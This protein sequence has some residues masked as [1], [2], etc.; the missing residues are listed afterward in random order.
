MSWYNIFKQSIC[1][2]ELS[3]IEDF[4]YQIEL[5]TKINQDMSSQ[6]EATKKQLN[7][8]N[9]NN[10]ILLN[11]INGYEKQI[12]YSFIPKEWTD[13]QG[14][15]ITNKYEEAGV[16][17]PLDIRDLLNSTV[18]SRQ[19]AEFI[20][21]KLDLAKEPDVVFNNICLA[22]NNVIAMVIKYKTNQAQ[23]EKL[24]IWFDGDIALVTGLGDCDISA[25]AVV[26]VINDC[27]EQLKMYEY[28]K[29][30]MQVIGFIPQGGHSWAEI[31]NPITNKFNLIEATDEYEKKELSETP[32]F[33]NRYFLLNNKKV[34]KINEEWQVFL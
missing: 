26:R 14:P 17:I 19:Y 8:A 16:S 3:K 22:A 32:A 27:L 21:K 12:N 10:Q 28:K 18:V 6:L 15:V 20:L 33:Y 7:D 24:D 4:K 9:I 31:Y 30:V 29:Y 11:K 25:R 5:S 23:F 13:I 1:K 34:F 2:T